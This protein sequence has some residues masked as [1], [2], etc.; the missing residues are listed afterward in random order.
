M[1]K[2]KQTGWAMQPEH[3]YICIGNEKK[4]TKQENVMMMKQKQD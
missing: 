2:K 1:N 3:I 4:K